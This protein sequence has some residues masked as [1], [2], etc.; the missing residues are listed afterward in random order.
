MKKWISELPEIEPYEVIINPGETLYLPAG[1][2]HQVYQ[3]DDT[4]AVNYWYDRIYDQS[5][6]KE[7][8]INTVLEK[9]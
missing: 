3:S 1:W 5:Y 9:A 2:F 8:F 4:I 7:T 6:T